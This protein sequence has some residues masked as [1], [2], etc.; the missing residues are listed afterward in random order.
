MRSVFGCAAAFVLVAPAAADLPAPVAATR[1]VDFQPPIPRGPTIPGSCWTS[2]IATNR[3]DAYRC[4]SGNEIFDPCFGSD[5]RSVVVCD[6]NPALGKPGF[7]LHLT[8][9]LPTST[10][11]PGP[12]TPWMVALTDGYICT[13]FTGTRATIEKQVIAYGCV[14]RGAAPRT[15]GP[16]IGLVGGTMTHGPVWRV[17]KAVYVPGPMGEAT[18]TIARVPIAAVWR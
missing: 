3:P 17:E 15:T 5:K 4:T 16:Y 2:S 10:P 11:L 12:V 18:G 7:A 14:K 6:P 8:K 1:I 9:P 13:P